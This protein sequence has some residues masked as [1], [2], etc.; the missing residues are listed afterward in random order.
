[1]SEPSLSLF[2]LSHAPFTKEAPDA[3]LWLPPSKQGLVDEL[4]DSHQERH[5]V[6]LVGEPGVGSLALSLSPRA[7]AAAVFY[8]V[9]GYLAT[10]HVASMR[11]RL[12]QSGTAPTCP[13]MACSMRH[14]LAEDVRTGRLLVRQDQAHC[15][16]SHFSRAANMAGITLASTIS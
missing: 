12:N 8:S 4:V 1:M 7:T 14:P 15:S 11:L 6:L 3:D 2:G 10:L 16:L 9:T 13:V 5:S